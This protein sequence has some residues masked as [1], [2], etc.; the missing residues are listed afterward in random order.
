MFVFLIL[1][2][3]YVLASP[4]IKG[5]ITMLSIFVPD[6]PLLHFCLLLSCKV[7]TIEVR[8]NSHTAL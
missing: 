6:I 5:Y 8:K 4:N 1:I 7:E 2:L 3:D